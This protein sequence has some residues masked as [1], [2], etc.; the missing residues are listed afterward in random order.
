MDKALEQA[1]NA[2][3]QGEVPVGAILIDNSTHNIITCA[4]NQINFLKNAT[5]HAE[6]NLINESCKKRQ[7]KFLTDTTL[8]VTLEPCAMCAAAICEVRISRLYFGAYENN[9]DSIENLLN[10]YKKRNYF[11][12]EV[13]GGINEIKCSNLLKSFFQ[14]KRINE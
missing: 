11:L 6:I 7:S 9:N 10:I 13:Y 2:L 3:L 12:P 4:H 14:K 5:L 1:N 8:F